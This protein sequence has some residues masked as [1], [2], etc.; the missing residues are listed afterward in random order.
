MEFL[1]LFENAVGVDQPYAYQQHLANHAW[2]A[3]I[4]QDSVR[5]RPSRWLGFANAYGGKCRRDA[6]NDG[7]WLVTRTYLERCASIYARKSSLM[8]V[9]YPLPRPLNHSRTSASRRS[10]TW[11]FL[12][13]GCSPFRATALANISAVISGCSDTSISSSRKA[14]I[15]FQS[16]WFVV[17][18]FLEIL[19]LLISRRFAYRNNADGV[20]AISMTDGNNPSIKQPEGQEAQFAIKDIC[21]FSAALSCGLIY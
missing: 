1:E 13:R 12:G 9:W 17:R 5:P 19:L 4:S 3:R 2:P 6:V 18:E 10:V 20:S 15:R 8:R 11:S 21:K 16:V 14:S 7:G